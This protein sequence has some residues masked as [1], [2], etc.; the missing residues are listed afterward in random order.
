LSVFSWLKCSLGQAANEA[1]A[2]R[3]VGFA[4]YHCKAFS[5]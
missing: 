4:D 5:L 2:A 1:I 3:N